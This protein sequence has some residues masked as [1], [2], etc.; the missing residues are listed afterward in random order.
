MNGHFQWRG[1]RLFC[2]GVMVARAIPNRSSFQP[3]WFAEY[4]SAIRGPYMSA[5]RAKVAIE[6]RFG[7]A[8]L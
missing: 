8:S 3:G 1:N 2:N 4:T 5:R 6:K 7:L